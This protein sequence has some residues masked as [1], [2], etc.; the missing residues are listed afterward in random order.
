MNNG[1]CADLP[2]AATNN[3]KVMIN[4]VVSP[5][6]NCP[7]PAKTVLNS[8]DPKFANIKNIAIKN[9]RSPILFMT[10]AFLAALP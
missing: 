4:N 8:K 9:P 10:N 5:I 3:N 7:A 1:I 6:A 2:V